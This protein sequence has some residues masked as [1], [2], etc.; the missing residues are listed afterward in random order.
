MI[1]VNQGFVN[2]LGCFICKDQ[3]GLEFFYH[4][5]YR[6]EFR[7]SREEFVEKYWEKSLSWDDSLGKHHLVPWDSNQSIDNV[8]SGILS[9]LYDMCGGDK[10]LEKLFSLLPKY[11][12]KRRG[13]N[14]DKLDQNGATHIF[15]SATIKS[16]FK[17]ELLLFF[18]SLNWKIDKN[19]I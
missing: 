5:L 3:L 13:K 18:R 12:K 11:S 19:L 6:D 14:Y 4:G 9:I 1:W 17:T 16:F 8:W 7:K 15:V 2:I 10:F